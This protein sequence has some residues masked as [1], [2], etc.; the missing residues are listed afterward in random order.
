MLFNQRCFL[1]FFVSF[2]GRGIVNSS[3]RQVG[4]FTADIKSTYMWDNTLIV[5]LTDSIQFSLNLLVV[6]S[7]MQI[8]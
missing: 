4:D 6:C 2:L 1:I 8:M 5:C 3:M 7:R